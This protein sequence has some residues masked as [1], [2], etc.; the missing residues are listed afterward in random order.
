MPHHHEH[1]CEH[2][3][4]KYCKVCRVVYCAKCG[5][6][7]KEGI[8]YYPY[9]TYPYTNPYPTWTTGTLT[10]DTD[11]MWTVDTTSSGCTHT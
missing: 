11:S 4:V 6:E 5:K 2:E 8:W 10:T 1:C 7:W 9:Y 3:Q